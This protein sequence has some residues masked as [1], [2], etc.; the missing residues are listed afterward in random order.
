MDWVDKVSQ[1]VL[2]VHGDN[3]QLIP[4]SFGKALYESYRS[5]KKKWLTVKD[6]NHN[7]IL[8]TPMPLYAE[9]ADWV[10]EHF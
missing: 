9:M 1:P 7:N 10:L 6:G 3:D 4:A 8:I 2:V 5:E